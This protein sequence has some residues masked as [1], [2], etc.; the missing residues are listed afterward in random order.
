M[1]SKNLIC[2]QLGGGIDG[3]NFLSP[4]DSASVARLQ[5]LRQG[6]PSN[7]LNYTD[8][9]LK[10][11]DLTAGS[12]IVA[13]IDITGIN[14]GDK[15]YGTDLKASRGLL[16][17]ALGTGQI[18][19]SD[20]AYTTVVGSS[21]STG[22]QS[23]LYKLN[24][25]AVSARNP[26][27]H[28]TQTFLSDAF[29]T[30]DI[31]GNASKTKAAVICNIGA[32][33]KP[34]TLVAGNLTVT[35]TGASAVSGI[36]IPAFLTSHN[37]Q[38][39]TVQS[40][41]PEGAVK[42]WGGGIADIFLPTLSGI[43]IPL[44]SISSSNLP[45]FSAGTDAKT[46][47]ISANGL[48]RKIPD[49]NGGYTRNSN[50]TVASTLKSAF[51][52]AMASYPVNDEISDSSILTN[53]LAV[54]YQPIL[55]NVMEIT[56]VPANLSFNIAGSV[57]LSAKPFL[58][59]LKSIA[60]MILA[61]NPRR[62]ATATRS[63]TTV[64]VATEISNG[65]ANRVAGSAIVTITATNHRLFT[66][67]LNTNNFTDSIVINTASFDTTVPVNGYKVTILPSD[68]NNSFTLTT[69]ATTALT[70]FPITFRLKH[71]LSSINNVFMTDATV[72]FDSVI[73]TNGY[74]V[75]TTPDNTSFTLTT[76]D[77]GAFTG[78]T[79]NLNFKLINLPKQVYYT[80]TPG[81]S[82]D[83]HPE[84]NHSQLAALNAGCDYFN[85]LVSKINDAD[86]VTFVSSEFGRTLSTNSQGTD[87]GWGNNYFAFG[88]SVKGNKVYGDVM[89]Y[90][91][92]GAHLTNNYMMPTTSI[93]Q[94]GATLAKWMGS[95]D[96]QVLDLFPD[97]INWSAAQR[98]LGFL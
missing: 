37:D 52:S 35:A 8:A 26:A 34:L 70:N 77:S 56:D 14:I 64:A 88:K 20:I 24:D 31:V 75:V 22:I 73:P 3:M 95:T 66:S 17:T 76:T 96:S 68:E 18:T 7:I 92:G 15:V 21:L 27:L 80:E 41:R 55:N 9:L 85:S 38:T 79:I 98:Y 39:S 44:A 5:S 65:V 11:G 82:W 45:V 86:C 91:V 63:G 10:T 2:I 60:K 48:I 54:N 57:S 71:N 19:L 29:N 1:A 58:S 13:N 72:I 94:Y 46:F 49:F 90:S 62:G 87:H 53:T 40:N 36:D 59:N 6:A 43:N 97:L 78:T 83:S 23:T 4:R 33:R 84:A 12:A 61:N 74:Q 81:F 93:Y 28:Y 25:S 47:T 89:D 30:T 67:T 42:G 69:V 51:L 32:L 50:I 16:V